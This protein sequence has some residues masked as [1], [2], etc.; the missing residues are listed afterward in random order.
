MAT[1]A[2]LYLD[3]LASSNT[4]SFDSNTFTLSGAIFGGGAIYIRARGPTG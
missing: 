1:K 4:M 2:I 3:F